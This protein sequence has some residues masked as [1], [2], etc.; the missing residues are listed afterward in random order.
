MERRRQEMVD[1]WTEQNEEKQALN[2]L[3]ADEKQRQAEQLQLDRE[4]AQ[5]ERQINE[6]KRLE[7]Q[8]M[9]RNELQ[10]QIDEL[11]KYFSL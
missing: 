6:R 1:I 7:K 9:L 2:C 5:L 4:Q 10:S 8:Q 11:S 3:Q